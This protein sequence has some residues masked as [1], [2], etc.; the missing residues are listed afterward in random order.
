MEGSSSFLTAATGVQPA[1]GHLSVPKRV[2]DP[3]R[4]DVPRNARNKGNESDSNYNINN[5]AIDAWATL[6]VSSPSSSFSTSGTSSAGGGLPDG[7][8]R[9]KSG[10]WLSA[11][12]TAGDINDPIGFDVSDSDHTNGN[13]SYKS[14][15]NHI[16]GAGTLMDVGLAVG[17]PE[18]AGQKEGAARGSL[19]RS[20]KDVGGPRK[21][22]RAKD[23]KPSQKDK[24]V[25]GK[26]K[27]TESHQK[28]KKKKKKTDKGKGSGSKKRKGGKGPTTTTTKEKKEEEKNSKSK[29]AKKTDK[30]SNATTT[31]KRKTTSSM[32]KSRSSPKKLMYICPISGCEL[33]RFF[34]F[35]FLFLFSF[36]FFLFLCYLS[37]S[38][39][40][41]F[42]F[43]FGAIR[44]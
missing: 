44:S 3:G 29:A 26:M 8:K 39:R 13:G 1:N 30:T 37:I 41:F 34:F 5:D 25:N 20:E 11:D 43:F 7:G 28:K 10:G 32:P 35:F 12:F 18:S 21:D 27:T 33:V 42:C 6:P 14:F 17:L 4:S 38:L 24:T 9:R 23:A 16:S 19:N 15:L 2:E 22:I 40:C 31:K 36:F